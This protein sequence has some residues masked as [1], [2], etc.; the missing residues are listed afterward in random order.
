MLKQSIQRTLQVAQRDA[1][2]CC[3][4]EETNY[5]LEGCLRDFAGGPAIPTADCAMI[6]KDLQGATIPGWMKTAVVESVQDKMLCANGEQKKGIRG[7]CDDTITCTTTS[8]EDWDD[9]TS[10]AKGLSTKVQV[11]RSLSIWHATLGQWENSSVPLGF[12][13]ESCRPAAKRPKHSALEV[14]PSMTTKAYKDGP[15][16][17]C[18]WVLITFWIWQLFYQQGQPML[19]WNTPG[20]ETNRS[21][22]V[23]AC[24]M[25][26]SITCWPNALMERL[27]SQ[28]NGETSQAALTF[29]G[30][31][32]NLKKRKNPLALGV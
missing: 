22:R 16:A 23:P 20:V 7:L 25:P 2:I 5:V 29:L 18:A 28:Q 15:P 1:L 6:I 12:Y 21:R 27:F 24:G 13:K 26:T 19:R 3:L 14:Y 11:F 8:Q 31:G 10:E 17:K 32:Q 9:L 4:Q 30:N